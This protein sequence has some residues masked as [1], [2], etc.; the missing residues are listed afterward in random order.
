MVWFNSVAGEFTPRALEFAGRPI[1]YVEIGCW[2]GVSA[3]W[4]SKNVLT[5]PDSQGFGIDPYEEL[6]RAMIPE[7]KLTH[8]EEK[9]RRVKESAHKN[10]AA[11]TNRWTW[12][13]KRSIDALVN[14][15]HGEIDFL[16]IDGLHRTMDVLLDFVL[17]WPH[18]KVGSG[19]I[20]DDYE[21]NARKGPNGVPE[22]ITAIDIAFGN[23]LV[24]W[25]EKHIR[26]QAAYKV[27]SKTA[28]KKWFSGQKDKRLWLEKLR[29]ER[30]QKVWME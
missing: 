20:F 4:V 1:T 27:R 28:D 30:E 3:A 24:P 21:I 5:H 6:R 9:M 7:G 19:V 29:R 2:E 15:E 22:A 13:E 12:I 17:S 16:Y 25:G 8:S 11:V 14:W 26:M 18:L 10:V 23:A